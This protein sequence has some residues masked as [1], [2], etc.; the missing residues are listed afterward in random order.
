MGIRWR[1]SPTRYMHSASLNTRRRRNG[2]QS[3]G[4]PRRVKLRLNI[5]RFL[6]RQTDTAFPIVQSS[7][8]F[9][10]VT[11]QRIQQAL[12]P[13]VFLAALHIRESNIPSVD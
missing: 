4:G 9:E 11:R 5:I 6:P 3:L 10:W 13:A 7:C 1:A 8:V 12:D 2:A